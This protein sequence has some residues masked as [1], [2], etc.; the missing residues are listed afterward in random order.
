MTGLIILA[1]IWFSLWII[2]GCAVEKLLKEILAE[3][4]KPKEGLHAE[5]QSDH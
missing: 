3:L 5:P 2:H 4:K 1:G